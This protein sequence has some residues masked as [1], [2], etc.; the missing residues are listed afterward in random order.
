[1]TQ[2][3]LFESI[4]VP[5]IQYLN[6]EAIKIRQQV[7]EEGKESHPLLSQSRFQPN[8][9]EESIH[10]EGKETLNIKTRSVVT[11][12]EYEIGRYFLTKTGWV[13]LVGEGFDKLINICRQIYGVE[14]I[15]RHLSL[16]AIT[17]AAF[18]WLQSVH[19]Q[20]LEPT[21]N[22]TT[23]VE[24]LIE[25]CASSVQSLD[26][27]VPLSGMELENSFRL[28]EV[29]F[30]NVRRNDVENWLVQWN[31]HWSSG[32]HP[33][34]ERVDRFFSVLGS[35]LDKDEIPVGVISV[36]AEPV[37]A[38]E[39]ALDEV[40][41]TLGFLRFY[42]Q[43]NFFPYAMSRCAIA[44]TLNQEIP[45]HILLNGDHLIGA[46]RTSSRWPN[47]P[48]EQFNDVIL[49]RLRSA[50]LSKLDYMLR[51]EEAQRTPFQKQLMRSL[52]VY[53]RSSIANHSRDKLLNV[54]VALES[55]LVRANEGS[56]RRNVAYRMAYLSGE[57]LE[58]RRE[59][60]N[61]Y[62]KAYEARSNIVHRGDEPQDMDI[63]SQFLN[64]AWQSFKILID[65]CDTYLSK[66][67]L[68]TSLDD[69]K[70]M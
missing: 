38:V 36:T 20:P 13:G 50:G 65:N 28:G 41:R 12:E 16:S 32:S 48:R 52:E 37:K 21:A 10:F 6:E 33:Q 35:R 44:G 55:I 24:N 62:Y 31:T 68:L 46:G 58:E 66:E 2:L 64:H 61:I 15:S 3:T 17:D 59:I 67:D 40:E 34:R 5:L 1:M 22:G 47:F 60:I 9:P 8:W 14:I 70:F 30:R 4:P 53:S 18:E 25:R 69:M 63:L 27:W 23:F 49:H 54:V 45:Q 7:C 56:L 43:S 11:I 42:S 39:R 29:T 57:S 26:V 19:G 51:L